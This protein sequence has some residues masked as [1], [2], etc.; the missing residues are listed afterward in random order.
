[1]LKNVNY[2]KIKE[3]MQLENRSY[4]VREK[5]LFYNFNLVIIH[6]IYEVSKKTFGDI[7]FIANVFK[8][9]DVE[10]PTKLAFSL[11]KQYGDS[12]INLL[13]VRIDKNWFELWIEEMKG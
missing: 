1:M 3:M 5:I 4:M 11:K 6:S 9:D 7:A 12:V 2:I 10:V 8:V 13:L